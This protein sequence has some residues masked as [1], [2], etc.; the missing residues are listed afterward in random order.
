LSPTHTTLNIHRQLPSF[1][2]SPLPFPGFPASPKATPLLSLSLSKIPNKSPA[3]MNQPDPGKMTHQQ[4]K[5]VQ[6]QGPRPPPLKV[7]KGSHKIRKP[8]PHPPPKQPPKPFQTQ[9]PP[10][11]PVIIYS[12]SPKVIHATASN[13]MY[14]VQRLTGPSSSTSPPGAG[15]LSPA[16]RLASI[17]KTSPSERDRDRD[18]DSST[19]AVMDIMEG[20][21]FLDLGEAYPGILSP[22]PAN[23]PPIPD[24]FFSPFNDPQNFPLFHDLSPVWHNGFSASPSGLPSASLISPSPSSMD[25]LRRFLDF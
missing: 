2:P 11:Q 6:L 21:E 3:E 14:I 19:A 9:Q 1:Q 22:A 10:Q 7:S 15:D 5:E 8:P 4:K 25:L 20:D 23:L 18:R 13:F 24:G 16:A 17:E 12:V